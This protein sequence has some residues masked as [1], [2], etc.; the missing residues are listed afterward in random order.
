MLSFERHGDAVGAKAINLTNKPRE[1]AMRQW[2]FFALGTALLSGCAAF[3]PQPLSKVDQRHVYVWP[4]LA[5]PSAEKPTHAA[6]AEFFPIASVLISTLVNAAVAMTC[7]RFVEPF[8]PGKWL[9]W[10]ASEWV[11][12]PA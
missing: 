11:D 6:R 10:G 2:S 12:G 4:A 9:G 3:L 8:I 5:C 7:L 1:T